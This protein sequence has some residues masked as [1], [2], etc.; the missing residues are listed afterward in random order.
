MLV[1]YLLCRTHNK[2]TEFGADL[3]TPAANV[4]AFTGHSDQ[5]DS[6]V[7]QFLCDAVRHFLEASGKAP[8]HKGILLTI[9]VRAA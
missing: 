9:T 7:W 1:S 6:T 5:S 4:M 3:I 2:I 8:Y